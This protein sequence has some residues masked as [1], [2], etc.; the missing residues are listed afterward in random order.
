MDKHSDGGEVSTVMCPHPGVHMYHNETRFG[1]KDS[2]VTEMKCSSN[3]SGRKDDYIPVNERVDGSYRVTLCSSS[4][5][6]QCY[7]GYANIDST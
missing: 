4:K 6:D 7:A 2:T 5:P 3:H 1:E